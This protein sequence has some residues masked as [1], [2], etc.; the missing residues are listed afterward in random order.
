MSETTH[1]LH[2][3][4]RGFLNFPNSQTVKYQDEI[5]A[6]SFKGNQ[7]MKISETSKLTEKDFLVL[8][9]LI[10]PDD[11]WE[12]VAERWR[13]HLARDMLVLEKLGRVVQL[14][15]SVEPTINLQ[16]AQEA[17]AGLKTRVPAVK[18]QM[19]QEA[20]KKENESTAFAEFKAINHRQMSVIESYRAAVHSRLSQ[21][22]EA[23]ETLERVFKHCHDNP[24][25]TENL[26]LMVD[27]LTYY[28][29]LSTELENPITLNGVNPMGSEAPGEEVL[30][31]L[32]ENSVLL[33]TQDSNQKPILV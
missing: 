26:K 7:F 29:T 22:K 2:E 32:F 20:F 19:F 11:L 30:A 1:E 18:D 6:F 4:R 10:L 13:P 12:R 28:A 16:T 15:S 21:L 24:Q 27:S 23:M 25:E 9:A 33:I 14:Y 17:F 31:K 3:T 8:D 5:A